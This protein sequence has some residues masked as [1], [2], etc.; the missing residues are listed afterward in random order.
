LVRR[1]RGHGQAAPTDYPAIQEFIVSA[2][3]KK[4]EKPKQPIPPWAWAFVVACGI[5]PVLTLGGAIPGA[6]GFGGAGGCI[7][8]ARSPS[9]ALGIKLAVCTA[10][11]V[12]CWVLVIVLLGG[13]LLLQQK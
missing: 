13:L 7:A 6:I 11:T 10:I 3:T 1:F 5:I 2:E 12:V 8:V 9:M 4:P